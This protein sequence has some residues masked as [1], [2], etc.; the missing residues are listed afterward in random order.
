MVWM[1]YPL[2]GV[3]NVEIPTVKSNIHQ[4]TLGS[5][6]PWLWPNMLPRCEEPDASRRH[7]NKQRSTF[8]LRFAN[9][10]A[11]LGGTGWHHD[12]PRKSE[13]RIY[14]VVQPELPTQG[15]A[16]GAEC[17]WVC[18]KMPHAV[19][20]V[21]LGGMICG[22]DSGYDAQVWFADLDLVFPYIPHVGLFTHSYQ[23]PPK[24]FKG[25]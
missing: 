5:N 17:I 20:D 10:K 8:N 13:N 6:K 1:T 11:F 9:A 3:H 21:C 23:L 2:I 25:Y 14:A 16:T 7:S 4:H 15:P 18:L 19:W 12:S 24:C 22:C